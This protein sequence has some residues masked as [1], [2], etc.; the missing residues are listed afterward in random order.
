MANPASAPET[1]MIGN[2]LDFAIM[3]STNNLGP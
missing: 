3:R 1:L 2:L